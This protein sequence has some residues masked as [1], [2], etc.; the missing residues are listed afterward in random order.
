MQ[1]VYEYIG[2][3]H[4]HTP[5]S[6]GE[7]SHTEIAQAAVQAGLDFVIVTDHNVLVQGVEGYY[8]F[9]TD[10]NVLLLT[11]EEVHDPRRQPQV[12]HMLIYGVEHELAPHAPNLQ[13][14][15]EQVEAVEG[16]C[17][18]AHPLERAAPLFDEPAIP[19][20]DWSIEGYTGI[21]LWNYMSEFKSY[22]SSPLAAIRAAFH[23]ERFISGPFPQTLALW[24]QLL[25]EGHRVKI[26]GGAD[27]HANRH[28][29]GPISRVVFP[30][31]YL[32]RCVNLHILT[33]R[34]FSGDLE[35]DKQLVLHALRD[36]NAFVGYDLPASTRGF[37]FSASGLNTH[38]IMGNWLRAGDGV[39]LQV[40]C[41]QIAQSRLIHNG[42]VVLEEAEGTHSTFI[43]TQPGA[44]RVEV[45]LPFKGKPR[46]WIFSNPIFLTG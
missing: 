27:A 30:Y 17:Y 22:L 23:P 16:A 13:T 26:V 42:R 24:D 10:Q 38:A 33:P 29:L 28:S 45:Y 14:L 15:I 1:P 43:A 31:E 44:Y 39:T 3:A 4:M 12:N 11:G 36:G 8:H 7:G 20:V 37:R 5:Y 34:P 32:F 19:W 9:G 35:H 21:E 2:N 40:A 41:P 6:D 46:G 18:L 25:G